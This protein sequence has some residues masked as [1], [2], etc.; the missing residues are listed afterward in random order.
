[1]IILNTTFHIAEPDVPAVL[2]WLRA[3]YIPA[4]ERMG[5]TRPELTRVL[6]TVADGCQTYA[7]H[8]RAESLAL[9]QRFAAGAGGKLLAILASRYGD[10][11][12]H[13]STML[14]LL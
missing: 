1:M 5:L 9:A 6:A 8:L 11:A 4:A 7:L 12:L 10:R 14:E 13:F 3:S 2:A